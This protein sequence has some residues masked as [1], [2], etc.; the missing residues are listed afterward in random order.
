[1]QQRVREA[2]ID[3]LK[4]APPGRILDIPCGHAWLKEKLDHYWDYYVAD[5]FTAPHLD[6]FKKVDLN[7]ELRYENDF[8]DYVACFEGLE[9]IENYHLVLREFHRILKKGGL[10]L[11]ATPNILNIKS[12]RRFFLYGTFYGFPH[13]VNLPSPGEHVHLNPINPSFLISFSE[14]YGFIFNEI[15]PIKIKLKMFRF[16][17]H[18]LLIK[19]YTNFKLVF[20]DEKTKLFI[21]RLVSLNILLNDE[22]LVAF[23]KP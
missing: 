5:L 19:L 11:I 16:I 17:I 4:K 2:I 8:F 14:K 20:K 15:Y 21:R 6:N 10:L 12:R 13:L 18:C 3:Y 9:H 22:I 23:Q 7:Q 1:V